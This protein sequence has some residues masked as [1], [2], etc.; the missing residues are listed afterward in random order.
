[1]RIG[2]Y[3]GYELTGSGSNE[4]T[5][6][7]SRALAMAGHE[8]HLL[9]REPRPETI[10]HVAEACDWSSDGVPSELFRRKTEV[11]G[12][13]TLHRLPHASVRPV[14]LTDKQREGDVR[15]FTRT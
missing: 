4:Y 15:A 3:H 9:C 6:Y 14:F 1:M 7:L 8:V 5:R 11:G 10:P 12:R 13:V 2:I